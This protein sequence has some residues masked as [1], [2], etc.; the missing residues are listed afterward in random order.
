MVTKA[1]GNTGGVG[2]KRAGA[3]RKPGVPN[4][5]K[6]ELAEQARE[7]TDEALK[8]LVRVM[9]DVEAPAAAVVTAANSILDR[10]HGKPSQAMK[11]EGDLFRNVDDNE[12]DRRILLL[13]TEL[14]IQA[15][16]AEGAGSAFGGAETTSRH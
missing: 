14:G 12:L 13:L 6:R 1:E 8:A 10:S 15:G 7:Y 5:V 11:I 9:R 16:K 3:G 2:G 4:K